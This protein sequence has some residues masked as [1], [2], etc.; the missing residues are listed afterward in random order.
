[1]NGGRV[2]GRARWRQFARRRNI[3][4]HSGHGLPHLEQRRVPVLPRW[5]FSKS[6]HSCVHSLMPKPP[7]LPQ[8]SHFW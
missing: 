4:R 2:A 8:G 5:S 3:R 1:M 6:F 7:K